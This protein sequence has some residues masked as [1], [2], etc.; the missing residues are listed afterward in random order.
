MKVYI[1]E[2]PSQHIFLIPKCEIDKRPSLS[3]PKIGCIQPMDDGTTRLDLPCFRE[4]SPERFGLVAEFLSTGKFGHPSVNPQNR[5]RY[6][7][8]CIQAWMIADRMVLEDLLDLVVV[9]IQ[10]T[11][12]WTLQEVMPLA[13]MVYEEEGSALQAY[14]TMKEMTAEAVADNFQAVAL[15]YREVFWRSFNELPELQRDVYRLL[16]ERAERKI[17]EG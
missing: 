15:E 14:T 10:E 7:E 8:Q 11:R 2:G 1:G 12:P 4:F 17:S 6:L 3:D 9:K 13:G 16:L 5:D